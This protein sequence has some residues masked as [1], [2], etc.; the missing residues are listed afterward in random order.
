[1]C[2]I[3]MFKASNRRCKGLLFEG[4]VFKALD[5]M[6]KAPDFMSKVPDF[7]LEQ[8][9]RHRLRQYI[10]LSYYGFPGMGGKTSL[11]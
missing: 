1:M 5:C 8:S 7:Q 4:A 6:S 9:K 2:R 10:T 3:L 11:H